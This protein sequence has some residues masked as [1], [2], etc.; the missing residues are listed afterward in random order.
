MGGNAAR[1]RDSESFRGENVKKVTTLL[2]IS[3]R[4]QR[5]TRLL[6]KGAF[7]GNARENINGLSE[8]VIVRVHDKKVLDHYENLRNFGSIDKQEENIDTVLVML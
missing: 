8:S 4:N 2:I 1:E 6:R 7:R 5:S 3:S